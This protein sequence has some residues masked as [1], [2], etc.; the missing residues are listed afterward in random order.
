MW[1]RHR[2]EAV[3]APCLI[4]L[5]VCQSERPPS[6]QHCLGLAALKV[7]QE[8]MCHII[9]P[10]I[11]ALLSPKLHV[12]FNFLSQGEGDVKAIY[13]YIIL[14]FLQ[15]RWRSGYCRHITAGSTPGLGP[16]CVEVLLSLCP[17]GLPPASSHNP[18]TCM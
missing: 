8:Q 11:S 12:C 1:H 6:R 13:I 7:K 5:Y 16:F 15:G 4:N 2:S 3:G 17:R 9:S 10:R 18:K 14:G